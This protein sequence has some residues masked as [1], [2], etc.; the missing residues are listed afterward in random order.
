MR[1][2]A[3]TVRRPGVRMAPTIST[4][5][6]CQVGAVKPCWNGCIHAASLVGASRLKPVP[7]IY[8]P[9]SAPGER[10]GR[11]ESA[12]NPLIDHIRFNVGEARMTGSRQ[13]A[14]ARSMENETKRRGLNDAAGGRAAPVSPLACDWHTPSQCGSEIP[15]SD[16]HRGTCETSRIDDGSDADCQ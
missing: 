12:A 7:A 15:C 5:T 9:E 14:V 11:A 4:S 2:A 10:L 1:R 16:R 3:A 13:A 6:C 8:S